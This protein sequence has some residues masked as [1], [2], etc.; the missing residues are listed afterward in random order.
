MRWWELLRSGACRRLRY[1]RIWF[2]DGWAF[3]L[4]IILVFGLI[5]AAP[6]LPIEPADSIRWLGISLELSGLFFVVIGLDRS[7][8]LFG[9]DRLLKSFTKWLSRVRYILVP[10]KPISL[11][12]NTLEL[13]AP[14]V[15]A[16]ALLLK[17]RPERIEDRLALLEDEVLQLHRDLSSLLNKLDQQ[18]VEVMQEIENE[19]RVRAS[20][21]HQINMRVEEAT[22]GGIRIELV[23]LTFL[24]FGIVFS[25]G[26]QEVAWVLSRLLP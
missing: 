25:S 15:S 9:K 3:V 5:V 2:Q 24:L 22:I 4:V 1:G 16:T 14:R 20:A 19:A 7:R 12:A 10:P 18:K 17:K 6:I 11:R 13:G 8:Q 21:D 23:G 26:S